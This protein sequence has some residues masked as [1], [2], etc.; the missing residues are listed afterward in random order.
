MVETTVAR[1]AHYSVSPDGQSETITLY[2]GERIEGT[3]GSNRYRIM[4]FDAAD[5]SDSHPAEPPRRAPRVDEMSTAQLLAQPRSATAGRTAVAPRA[6]DHDAGVRGAGGAAR[7]AAAAAGPL[8]TRV[9]RDPGVCASMRCWRRPGAAG[10]SAASCRRTL[11]LWWVHGLFLVIEH[12]RDA[13]ARDARARLR[14]GGV[15][16]EPARS[17]HRAHAAGGRGAGDGGAAD[18]RPAVH[19]H[20]RAERESASATTACSMR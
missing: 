16:D 8:C 9:A 5:R 2:D 19:L 14:S 3:P 12:R 20:R 18:A 7:A 4:H 13:A 6:A 1:R 10:S 15:A 11:G 17:L